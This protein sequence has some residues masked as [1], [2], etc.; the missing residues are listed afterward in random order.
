MPLC[1]LLPC[2]ALEQNQRQAAPS[3]PH[4]FVAYRSHFS[5]CIALS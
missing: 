4:F 1:G 3:R 5:T 2:A